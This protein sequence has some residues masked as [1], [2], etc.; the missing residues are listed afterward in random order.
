MQYSRRE[1]IEE[2]NNQKRAVI[3][4]ALSILTIII[5]FFFGIPLIAKFV[6]FI[7]DFTN[8]NTPI[9]LND[10]TPPAPPR[11]DNLPDATNKEIFEVTGTTEEGV[12]VYVFL[13]SSEKEII[14]DSYGEFATS[15]DLTKGENIIYA[16]SKDQSGNKSA[17]SE[18]YVILFDNENPEIS[19]NSPSN[20]DNFYGS[21]QKEIEITGKTD[22]NVNLTVND[23]YVSITDSGD[24][25]YKL[26]LNEGENILNFKAIDKAQNEAEK[27]VTVT[28]TP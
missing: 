23:R 25:K 20:G 21:G 3:F 5:L 13:N 12:T 6:S 8:K 7:S 10:N 16:I 11:F 14:A 28:F 9:T 19:I 22:P 15:L 27:T 1:A 18:K 26:S 17:E 4:V 24:F 2:K